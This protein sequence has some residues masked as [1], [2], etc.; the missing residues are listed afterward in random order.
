MIGA[1][2]PRADLYRF[3]LVFCARAD[4]AEV[5]CRPDHILHTAQLLLRDLVGILRFDEREVLLRSVEAAGIQN[6]PQLREGHDQA[7]AGINGV[8]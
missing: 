5:A 4:L 7:A 6:D 3:A 2:V 8:T 1:A